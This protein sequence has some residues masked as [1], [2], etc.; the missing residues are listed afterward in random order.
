MLDHYGDVVD[1]D[2]NETKVDDNYGFGDE[3]DGIS[4]RWVLVFGV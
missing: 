3:G 2:G 4:V 1:Q